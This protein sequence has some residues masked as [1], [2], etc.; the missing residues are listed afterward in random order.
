MYEKGD[1]RMTPRLPKGSLFK[2]FKVGDGGTEEQVV[3]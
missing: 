2:V 3:I 1:I